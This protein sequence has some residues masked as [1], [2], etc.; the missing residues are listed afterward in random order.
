[1][2]GATAEPCDN[3]TSPPNIKIDKMM[4]SNQN[5]LRVRIK[6]KISPSNDI[7]FPFVPLKID[8]LTCCFG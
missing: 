7:T 1:M 2:N 8:F 6:A 3:T 5:F 4:G